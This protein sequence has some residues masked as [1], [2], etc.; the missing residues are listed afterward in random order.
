MMI[1]TIMYDSSTGW[2]DDTEKQRSTYS[3][4]LLFFIPFPFLFLTTASPAS[5]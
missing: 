2:F 3:A 5:P 1:L 4:A